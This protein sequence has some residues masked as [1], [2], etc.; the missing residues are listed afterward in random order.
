M[1]KTSLSAATKIATEALAAQSAAVNALIPRIGQA[2]EQAV[3]LILKCPGRVVVCGMG[4]SGLVGQKIAAT[5]ASTGT[6]SFFLHPAEALHGDLGMIMPGDIVL[7]I[8]NSGET[9][10]VLRL[11]PALRE[12]GNT[13][14]AVT[15]GLQSSLAKASAHVLDISIEREICPLNLAPTTST[16]VTMAMGDALAVALMDARKFE[17][18]EFAR[19][20][21]GGN[22]GRRL[23]TKVRD[24]M[25]L[26]MPTITAQASLRDAMLKM[27]AG[28][29]GVALITDGTCLLGILTDGDLRRAFLERNA[30]LEDAITLHMTRSP[31]TVQPNMQWIEA[32]K[33]M[34]DKKIKLLVVVNPVSGDQPSEV[35]GLVEIYDL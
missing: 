4:K 34:L 19:F 30:K 3:A 33:I 7:L 27:T 32:E 35:V 17:P 6:P 15:G 29:L 28:R 11:L 12:F 22:L 21:P 9:D 2:F 26:D 24:V 1:P 20:H 31:I 14:I 5:F 8:S 23:L 13:V 10:E 25:H 18:H 16:L